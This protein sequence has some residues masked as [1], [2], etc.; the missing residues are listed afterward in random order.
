M[1]VKVKICGITRKEDALL[2]CEHGAFALGFVF[3]E[4]PR[5]ITM[6]KA[7]EIIKTLPEPLLSV[8]VFVNE[9]LTTILQHIEQTQITAVQL[10][11][12]ESAQ[13]ISELKSRTPETIVIK[14]IGVNEVGLVQN[15]DDFNDLDYFLFDSMESRRDWPTRPLILWKTLRHLRLNKPYFVAGGLNSENVIE[16]IKDLHP[17]GVDVS[18]GVEY[19]IGKK[20]PGAVRNFI[21]CV[22]ADYV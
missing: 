4:S 1:K 15:P 20:N 16:I 3:A 13:F 9:S 18:S 12:H 8:G 5:Q 6:D 7:R 10:H 14:S 19:E 17:Y 11:G 21:R 22:G 2:A